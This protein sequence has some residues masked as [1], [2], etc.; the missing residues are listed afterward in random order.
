MV[1][2]KVAFFRSVHDYFSR[3]ANNVYISK[4]LLELVAYH[5]IRFFPPV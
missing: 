4:K 1:T 3:I 2:A 5:F